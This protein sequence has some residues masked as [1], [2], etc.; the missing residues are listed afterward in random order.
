M[1]LKEGER[2]RSM[3]RETNVSLTRKEKKSMDRTSELV[4]L[5]LNNEILSFS[6]FI[7][8]C[9]RS[10][11][12]CAAGVL[13]TILMNIGIFIQAYHVKQEP[14]NFKLCDLVM[15]TMY[16]FHWLYDI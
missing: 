11:L 1:Y 6:L 8:G 4:P 5:A 7:S 16:F 12:I 14:N 15:G 2:D 3:A 9:V 13:K 10:R